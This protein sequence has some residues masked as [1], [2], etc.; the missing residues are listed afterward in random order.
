MSR[1]RRGAVWVLEVDPEHQLTRRQREILH[2]VRAHA[3]NRSR[4]A[5]SLG[6]TV[7]TV[8]YA[9]RAARLAGARVPPAPN[10]GAGRGPDLTPRRRAA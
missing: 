10:C 2:A 9:I 7:Q 5:R 8:Q 4:A 3:G 1:V 6:V